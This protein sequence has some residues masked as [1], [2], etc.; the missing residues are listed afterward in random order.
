MPQ[1]RIERNKWH[2]DRSQSKKL[3]RHQCLK[4]C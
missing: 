1:T 4:S 2:K 3:A